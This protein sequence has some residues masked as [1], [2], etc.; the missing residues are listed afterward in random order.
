MYVTAQQQQQ[1]QRRGGDD[2]KEGTLV[3]QTKERSNE[4][5]RESPRWDLNPRPKVSAS[6]SY[7]SAGLRNLRSAG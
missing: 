5:R 6:D 7:M 3:A 2:L 4:V 1:Q